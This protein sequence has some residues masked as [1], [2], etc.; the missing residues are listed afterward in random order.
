MAERTHQRGDLESASLIVVCGLSL[1]GL[2]ASLFALGLP[3][4][5]E[6]FPHGFAIA[7][8]AA[9]IVAA[10]ACAVVAVAGSSDA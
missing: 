5:A 7:F 8:P 2:A 9:G 10:A 1:A 6:T 3:R 4:M